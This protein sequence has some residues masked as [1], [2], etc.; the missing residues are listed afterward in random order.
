MK[1]TVLVDNNT[2]IDRYFLGEPG[3]SVLVEVDGLRVLLDCGYSGVFI[4]NA[5]RMNIDLLHLD[6]LVLSHGH[7]D[8]T[9]GLVDL[10]RLY[11]EAGINGIDLSRPRLLAHPEALVTRLANKIPEIGSLIGQDKLARHFDM[12]P[13]R[14][15]QWL[16]ERLVWLGEIPRKFDFEYV[17]PTERLLVSAEGETVPDELVDDGA[18]ACVTDQGLVVISGCSHSGVCNIVEHARE[19]TGQER[20]VDVLGGFHLLNAPEARLQATADYLGALNLE[21]LH[22]CHCT[23]LAARICLARTCPVRETGSGLVLEYPTNQ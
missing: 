6:W 19:V 11:T 20:V 1:A 22:A 2:I 8:H 3:L 18:L 17:G 23:D 12:A 13:S 7:L 15:P 21:S 16:S 14:E 4:E 9:W 5:R 10:I